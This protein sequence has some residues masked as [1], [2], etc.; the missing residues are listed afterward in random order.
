MT[1]SAG[2]SDIPPEPAPMLGIAREAHA[3]R[4]ASESAAVTPSRVAPTEE[5]HSML[6]RAAWMFTRRVR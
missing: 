1:T 6:M 3:S 4:S 5:R 2:S